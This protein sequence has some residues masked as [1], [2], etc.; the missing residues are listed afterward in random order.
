M[1]ENKRIEAGA[2][3]GGASRAQTREEEVRGGRFFWCYEHQC[4]HLERKS[5]YLPDHRTVVPVSLVKK[6]YPK[7]VAWVDP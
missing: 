1:S 3:L 2:K 6:Y 4:F 7:L 5:G